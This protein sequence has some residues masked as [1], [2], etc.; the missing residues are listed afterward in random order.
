MWYAWH[1]TYGIYAGQVYRYE[2]IQQEKIFKKDMSYY[3]Q[4]IDLAGV[5]I[6]F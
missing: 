2:S 3:H 6:P 4:I 1:R 5:A